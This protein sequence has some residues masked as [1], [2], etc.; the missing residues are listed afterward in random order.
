MK[1]TFCLLLAL[2]L[3][4]DI[5]VEKQAQ[6]LVPES[7]KNQILIPTAGKTPIS[8]SFGNNVNSMNVDGHKIEALPNNRRLN[9]HRKLDEEE[10]TTD[11]FASGD[12]S[13]L[14]DSGDSGET[15]GLIDGD[16]GA[17]SPTDEAVVDDGSAGQFDEDVVD[18]G[19]AGQFNEGDFGPISEP[20][21][22]NADEQGADNGD[23][24]NAQCPPDNDT[25]V[26]VLE[27]Y[28]GS[29]SQSLNAEA[30]IIDQD[31]SYLQSLQTTP[32]GGSIYLPVAT[33]RLLLD[34]LLD[35]KDFKD[36]FGCSPAGAADE[37]DGSGQ[38]SYQVHEQS[39][40]ELPIVDE[41]IH[42]D[43]GVIPNDNTRKRHLFVR[44]NVRGKMHHKV[45]RAVIRRHV[46]RRKATGVHGGNPLRPRFRVVQG[47]LQR[48]QVVRRNARLQRV[49][50]R[51]QLRRKLAGQPFVVHHPAAQITRHFN[52][53]IRKPIMRG[54]RVIP[55]RHLLKV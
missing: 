40:E 24:G 44:R 36:S 5:E 50:H 18:D 27:S 8:V 28:F 10:E 25:I 17:S 35:L 2:S 48:H 13:I 9:P 39:A 26:Q 32:D 38:C 15:G 3:R 4:A 30:N 7:Q 1:I 19:S 16:T 52:P 43:V 31:I 42:E 41:V 47:P 51:P 45:L 55:Q 49:V 11:P 37:D 33:V 14:I 21:P 46:F 34:K 22:I 6:P 20:A 12:G 29:D 23:Y 53:L 54:M